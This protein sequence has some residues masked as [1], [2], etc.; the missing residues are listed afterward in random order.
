M[1]NFSA[2]CAR[3]PILSSLIREA[4]FI[5]GAL[6]VMLQLVVARLWLSAKL[7]DRSCG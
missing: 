6:A 2:L 3:P 4:L 1:N 7:S 5:N